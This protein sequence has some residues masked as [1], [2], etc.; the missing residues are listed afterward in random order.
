M[1]N[2]AAITLGCAY[3]GGPVPATRRGSLYCCEGCAFVHGLQDAVPRAAPA[4]AKSVETILQVEGVTCAACVARVA[5]ALGAV[6]GVSE[7]SLNLAT[8][9]ARVVHDEGLGHEAL[10]RALG[11]AGYRAREARDPVE[12]ERAERRRSLWRIAL[13]GFAMMQIMM[14]ALPAYIADD[15]SLPWDVERLFAL[16]SLAL[17]LPVLAFSARPIFSAAWHG[18]RA[19]EPG[20]DLP[21]ALGIAVSFAASLAN[22]FSGGD[23]YYDSIAMFVFLLLGARHLEHAA[24]ARGADPTESLAQLLPRR[25]RRVGPDGFRDIE[26][27]ALRAGETVA[28]AVGEA[29]PADC[30]LLEGATH[31]DESLVTGESAPV[32]KRGGDAILAGTVNLSSP[33]QARVERAGA[34]QTLERIRALVERAAGDRPR[35]TLIADRIARRFAVAVVALAAAGAI[36]WSFVDPSRALAVAIATL[37]VSCPCALALATP[38]AVTA[39]VNRLA[40]R[41]ILVTRGRAL[42]ALASVTHVVFDK[43]GTLTTGR[44]RLSSLETFGREDRDRCLQLA[45]ALEVAL[46]HPIA[47][48]IAGAATGARLAAT[49]L[50]AFPGEGV[51]GLLG[52]VRYR[53]G[54]ARFCAQL[55]GGRAPFRDDASAPGAFLADEN[56]WLAAFRFEDALRPESAALIRH[57]R[58]A[59]C[60][61]VLLS[62]DRRA[63]VDPIAAALGISERIAAADPARK[64][65]FVARLIA[66]GARVAMVGDGVNDAPGL[67]GAHVAIAPANGTA[68]AQSQADFI[69]ANPS[70]LSIAEALD[71]ARRTRT[72]V[73]QNFA[74]AAAY[75]AVSVPL[76]LA[77]ILAPWMAA[78]GMSLSSLLV[79][80]NALRLARASPPPP[81]PAPPPVS[82]WTSSTSSSP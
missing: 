16:A 46:P 1:E 68:L 60:E 29:A 69:L 13:A 34:D 30:R 38:A 44:M 39:A 48:A 75:N 61:I 77:G 9:R 71:T 52:G 47:H 40:R 19:R 35:W 6:A 78:L 63:V 8:R 59:G 10:V 54:S 41:G 49:H 56:G 21:V 79:V 53:V 32:A 18:L 23:V 64:A 17:T 28:I 11:K 4:D 74:W 70:L 20:M 57:L 76:A 66:A 55:H 81:A 82:S 3:C 33:V 58:D 37:V 12:W 24:L 14:F 5:S 36:A 26:C 62:G 2:R 65:A 43:T 31:F 72:I 7:A 22:T 42:E 45:A 25:A 51:E 73:K 80:G 67:A 27:D 15:G 50:K